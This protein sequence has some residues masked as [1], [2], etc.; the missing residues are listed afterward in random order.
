MEMYFFLLL[1]QTAAQD[2]ALPT[3]NSA[4]VPASD[5]SPVA[6]SSDS[7]SSSSGSNSGASSNGITT[8]TPL[9]GEIDRRSSSIAALRMKAR[10]HEIRL[11]MIRKNGTDLLS[12]KPFIFPFFFFYYLPFFITFNLSRTLEDSMSSI[13]MLYFF[14]EIRGQVPLCLC[15]YLII[16]PQYLFAIVT[17]SFHLFP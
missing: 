17:I 11:E 14:L 12:Q 8:I 9:C 7:G 6:I 13:F 15:P 10:E 2:S 5:S 16:R 1:Q 4:V 3:V